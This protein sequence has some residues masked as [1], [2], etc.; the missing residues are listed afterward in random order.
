[1]TNVTGTNGNDI[2]SP[3]LVSEGVVGIPTAGD[4]IILALDGNDA[5]SG[6]GGNDTLDG[7]EGDDHLIGNGDDSMP[8]ALPVFWN[9]L[10][11][12]SG[13]AV[14]SEIGPDLADAGSET[15]FVPGF[16]GNAVTLAG[17]YSSTQRIHN[18][19]LNGLDSLLSPNHGTVELWYYQTAAPVAFQ[20][21]AYRLFD[22]A[23]GFD[24]GIGITIYEDGD[25]SNGG[26]RIL[27]NLGNG[28]ELVYA[29]DANG[30]IG[31]D[32]SSRSGQ[33]LH[34]A[35]T[36]DSGGINGSAD[37]MRVYLNNEIIETSQ[38]ALPASAFGS[39]ADIAGG[40][41][42]E[43]AGKFLAD[44]LKLW[45]F[46][47]TDFSDRFSEGLPVAVSDDDILL[48]GDGN[49]ILEGNGGNDLLTGG[50]GSDCF[51]GSPADLNGDRITDFTA[52]DSVVVQGVRFKSTA[53]SVEKHPEGW[54][55]LS[56]DTDD[57]GS[58]DTFLK[59]D[60]FFHGIFQVLPSAPEGDATTE[61]RFI[62]DLSNQM[63][64]AVD[65]N[66]VTAYGTPVAINILS[67]DSDPDGD[68]LQIDGVTD[69]V[70]G[71]L[72]F[73][74]DSGTITY[75]PNEG[76]SGTDSFTYSVTDRFGGT[77]TAT[78][79]I[80]VEPRPEHAPVAQDDYFYGM[81]GD[82]VFGN[83]LANDFD[84]DGD[85]PGI[86]SGPVG[87]NGS[88]SA[89]VWGS[90]NYGTYEIT[91]GKGG[92]ASAA[93]YVDGI[94]I[95][96]PDPTPW[97]PV[98]DPLPPEEVPPVSWPVPPAFEPWPPEGWI[99]P[100]IPDEGWWL[101]TPGDDTKTGTGNNDGM[102]FGAGS[103]VGSGGDGDDKMSGSNIPSANSVDIDVWSSKTTSSN[104][105]YI[106]SEGVTVDGELKD[107]T[108]VEFR[109]GD[110]GKL[111]FAVNVNGTWAGAYEYTG[112]DTPPSPD[113]PWYD[114]LRP[115]QNLND[116]LSGERGNDVAE[117]G[118]GND[119]LKGGAD[120]DV[121]NGGVGGDSLDGGTGDDGLWGDFGDD[122]LWGGDGDDRMWG[123][124]EN[125]PYYPDQDPGGIMPLPYFPDDDWMDG[126]T[127]NDWIFAGYGN[128]IMYGGDGIDSMYGGNGN[129]WMSGD[130]G[131]DWMY[132]S[133]GDDSLYGGSGSDSLFG[134]DGNDNLFGGSSPS[135]VAMV[136]ASN[137]VVNVSSNDLLSGGA[138]NDGLDGGEGEDILQG[139]SGTDILTGGLGKDIFQGTLAELNGD[140]ITDFDK[141]DTIEVAGV[142]FGNDALAFTG[143]VLSIDA[144]KN[145]IIDASINLNGASAAH[146]EASQSNP[147]NDAM[148]RI[149]I[150]ESPVIS[151]TPLDAIKPEGNTGGTSF[152]FKVT[153]EGDLSRESTVSYGVS[154]EIDAAD[155]ASGVLPGGTI[156]FTPGSAEQVLTLRVAGD[157][158]PEMHED[159]LVNLSNSING[160]LQRAA[161][162]GT[163][164][165]DDQLLIRIG[166][167]PI[168]ARPG[169]WEQSWTNE[170]V[171]IT[172]KADLTNVNEAYSRVLFS[173][174][175]SGKLEGGDIFQGDLG[176]SG[177]TQK[178]S[179]IKQ[180]IDGTEGL[181]FSLDEKANHVT[182]NLSS[183][184][185]NDDKTGMTEAGRVQFVN[186]NQI[187]KE[188][189]FSAD[190]SNGEKEISVELPAGFTDIVFASGALNNGNFVY[191]AYSNGTGSGFGAA[192]T[193]KHGSD[194]LID[195]VS[196]GF[197]GII[198]IGS[199]LPQNSIDSFVI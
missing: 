167:A 23:F 98:E 9:K 50:A 59:L 191:G 107:K 93:I 80:A 87:V 151:I 86:V 69:P 38:T 53:L 47:K 8:G 132:A 174:A 133:V 82:T 157:T 40:N 17:S 21:N 134:G 42:G 145:G 70:S 48:G 61:I 13:S 67:N 31:Y 161:A 30:D 140:T 172:H 125:L 173:T 100:E 28:A 68:V 196:F 197:G 176:V 198:P 51:A 46:A 22:G 25:A 92:F 99:P 119:V 95:P 122:E 168:Q 126:G 90:G 128:D 15:T 3:A 85:T 130:T 141:S 162:I 27:F 177:Q 110:D 104:E 105:S 71:S 164:L 6:G 112:G 81:I 142:R 129:D 39:S 84:P 136:N 194:Y 154:G 137:F 65:D 29:K 36:W 16:F 190:N 185:T 37:T 34:I 195:D 159:F 108:I 7:G 26:G 178:S 60:G 14:Y 179:A 149:R 199:T 148:T 101:D 91:D 184:F 114:N 35:A 124:L 66:A 192:P 24:P 187:V 163:I 33:W 57:S 88:F 64:E 138:G 156:I 45:D 55:D 189:Y 2:I 63:P 72:A 12:S 143:S 44:N 113:S 97:P 18:L 165:N 170:H 147:G 109:Q 121:L 73:Y 20:Y 116:T 54:L 10:D 186:Q 118:I 155:F 175:N 139:G 96:T 150:V 1:M 182:F 5:L 152:T 58:A 76:F 127:G 169:V 41:D 160:T 166:D 123:G 115:G 83:V 94:P 74:S 131:N 158:T 183:F 77:D 52:A 102:I 146:F 89:S 120:E 62:P 79:S 135:L 111:Y 78:V 32:V 49:D 153:R 144:D 56:I 188:V 171:S 4:D 193:A 180:E 181:R 75:L 117:G 106:W 11:S 43:I 19:T 103:D